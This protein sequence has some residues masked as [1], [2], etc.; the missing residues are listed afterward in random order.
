MD[1][2]SPGSSHISVIVRST[3]VVACS[4]HHQ[5][6]SSA[7]YHSVLGPIL[8]MMYTTNLIALTERHGFRP[9]LYADD[10][11]IYGSCRPQAIHDLQLR[12]SAYIDDVHNWMQSNRLRLNTN[13][14][15]ELLWCATTRRQHQLPRS[16]CRIWTDD[17]IL[18]TTVRD[19]GTALT[20]ISACGLSRLMQRTVVDCFAVLRQLR[21]NR[22][23]VP[24]SVFQTLVVALCCQDCTTVMPHWPVFPPI[25][26]NVPAVCAKCFCSVNRRSSSLGSYTQTL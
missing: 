5:S 20:Q 12:L 2:F 10:T 19:L 9:H 24:S 22:R 15:T 4:D 8:F 1:Q 23:S 7:E 13:I 16:A 14:K 18:S 6:G 11:Q 3:S 17:I 25:C 21:S 26:L